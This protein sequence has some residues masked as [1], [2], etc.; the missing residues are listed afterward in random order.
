MPSLSERRILVTGA[1]GGIGSALVKRL[2]A[3]GASLWLAGRDEGKLSALAGELGKAASRHTLVAGV[4]LTTAMG[5]QRLLDQLSQAAPEQRPSTLVHLAGIN[6]LGWFRETSPDDVTRV[7]DTN[8]TSTLLL[9][10]ALLPLFLGQPSANLLFVGSLLG[11]I[12]HPGYVAYCASKA[13]LKGFAEA[14][15]RELEDT[16]VRV[17]YLA[18]RATRTAMNGPDAEAMNE[19][20][21]NTVDSPERVA[22]AIIKQ[23]TRGQ[24][25]AVLGGKERLFALINAIAPTLV[26]RAIARSRADISRHLDPPA[27]VVQ[28]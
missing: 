23:L 24:R 8:L 5:R 4:D 14:L 20:L 18:P 13:G 10:Q 11:H 27:Q 26:D 25:R 21:G 15:S 16:S 17:Q 28:D 3:E 12:G 19:A 7:L 2:D 9:T 6:H 22:D 1:T